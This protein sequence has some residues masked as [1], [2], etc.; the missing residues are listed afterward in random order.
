[1][2]MRSF[3]TENIVTEK[4]YLPGRQRFKNYWCSNYI[5]DSSIRGISP[6]GRNDSSIRGISPFGRNDRRYTWDFFPH[7]GQG[8]PVEITQK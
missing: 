8:P 2:K 6:S 1:M 3:V 4:T 7:T 5:R